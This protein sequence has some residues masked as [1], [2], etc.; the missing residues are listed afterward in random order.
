MTGLR[1]RDRV[2]NQLAALNLCSEVVAQDGGRV[3]CVGNLGPDEP[4]LPVHMNRPLHHAARPG[5]QHERHHE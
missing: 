5:Q 1:R 3:E 4:M 2:G